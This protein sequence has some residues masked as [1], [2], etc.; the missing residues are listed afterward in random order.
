MKF[1]LALFNPVTEAAV[2]AAPSA[3]PA[4]T[5]AAPTPAPTP[6]RSAGDF[7]GRPGPA[8][9][10]K[11]DESQ[12]PPP[13]ARTSFID[14]INETV[15]KP[16]APAVEAK[17]EPAKPV[18]KP[19]PAVEKPVEAA[20]PDFDLSDWLKQHVPEAP[21]GV[22][23]TKLGEFKG[24]RELLSKALT[25]LKAQATENM[26][27]KRGVPAPEAQKQVAAP[28]PETE[29]VKKLTLEYQQLQTKYDTE[30]KAFNESK[31]KAEL[32]DNPA[33]M[34]QFDG[35]RANLV[36]EMTSVAQDAG[37]DAKIIEELTKAGSEY[38]I[39]KVLEEVEDK[40]AKA[41][42]AAKAKEFVGIS[43]QKDAAMSNPLTELQ[44][45]RDYQDGLN[46]TMVS[47]MT[48]KMR[49]AYLQATVDVGPALAK[50]DVYFSTPAGRATLESLN[51]RFQNGLDLTP[52]EIV[53]ALAKRDAFEAYR[54]Y[55]EVQQKRIAE[56]TA[57]NARYAEAANTSSATDPSAPGGGQGGGG[58][59]SMS[60][61]W[62]GKK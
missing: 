4:P 28:L 44:R 15:K 25:D 6:Q 3:S 16:A 24:I 7:M 33:F 20:K 50:E 26:M 40:T 19:A 49:G 31:A 10:A 12:A 46:G 29:A 21:D 53:G 37:I 56:L 18:E 39:G 51:L 57:E 22:P 54:D 45:W 41:L 17:P 42:L 13:A 14:R 11:P 55:A 35:T 47:A 48:D 32:A 60:S 9:P 43:K 5:P 2:E 58:G 36:D 62:G 61:V 23:A 8:A 38:K 59:F 30:L 27:L 1:P 52:A 34:A